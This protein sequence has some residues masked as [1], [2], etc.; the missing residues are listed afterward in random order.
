MR[1]D[2]RVNPEIKLGYT[3]LER[4][5]GFLCH[6]AMVCG[7]LFPYLKDF[8]FTLSP[9]LL[10]RD[11]E[12]WKMNDLQWIGHV[13]WKVDQGEMTREKADLILVSPSGGDADPDK[14]ITPVPRCH[15]NIKAFN[16]FFSSDKPPIIVNR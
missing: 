15:S 9:H 1:E 8:H 13:E 12:G 3:R 16:E 2:L 4:I 14:Y 11:N 5:G 7:I 6:L 10:R